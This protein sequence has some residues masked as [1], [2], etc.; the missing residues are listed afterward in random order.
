MSVLMYQVIFMLIRLFIK[1]FPQENFSLLSLLLPYFLQML[2]HTDLCTLPSSPAFPRLILRDVRNI[3]QATQSPTSN[4]K[5]HMRHILIVF[6]LTEF[7]ALCCACQCVGLP[8]KQFLSFGS[9]QKCC[10][11]YY[12][13][14]VETECKKQSRGDLSDFFLFSLGREES[15]PHCCSW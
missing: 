10:C 1:N 5:C 2:C 13:T 7:I 9:D 14:D 11:Q 6:P 3:S 12:F 8:H 4:E 15:C